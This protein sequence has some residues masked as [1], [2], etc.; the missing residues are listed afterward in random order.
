MRWF[1]AVMGQRDLV[2]N[3]YRYDAYV[4]AD[5]DFNTLYTSYI[6]RYRKLKLKR[7][8]L[9]VVKIFKR[10]EKKK[11]SNSAR[12]TFEGFFFVYLP[13]YLPT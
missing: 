11:Q 8:Y 12:F 10:V 5:K 6:I 13:T 3:Y 1:V 9:R 2:E 7:E 4:F